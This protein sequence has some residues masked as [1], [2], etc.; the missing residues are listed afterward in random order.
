MEKKEKRKK[1]E[2][3]GEHHRQVTKNTHVTV[4][5]Y[6]KTTE[7]TEEQCKPQLEKLITEDRT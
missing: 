1:E 5:F 3:K 4:S 2:E 7:V 6:F